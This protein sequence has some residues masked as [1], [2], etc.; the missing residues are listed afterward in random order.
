MNNTICTKVP[1]PWIP[2]ELDLTPTQAIAKVWGRVYTWE[3]S[4]LPVSILTAGKELL[5]APARLRALFDGSESAFTKI[6]YTP[7]SVE[8]EK[9]IFVV[10]A[11]VGNITLNI[12]Y[13]IEYDGFIEMVLSVI[14]FWS[15]SSDP[16]DTVPRL[17]GLYFEFPIR[18]DLSSLYHFWPNGESGII[19][20][21]SIIGSGALPETGL[22]LPFKPYVWSGWE[23]GGLSITTE[24]DENVQLTPGT[25]Y[26]S[27][28]NEADRRVLRWNL[29]N[30]VPHQWFGRV[31]R[32]TE[33]LP[34]VEYKFALQATPV[35]E[36]RKDRMDIRI[37]FAGLDTEGNCLVPDEDGECL[38]DKYQ[39]AGVTWVQF[40]E[41]WSAIQNYGQSINE[42][43][44][45]TYVQE[46]HK[47]GLKIMVYFGY[48]MSTNAPMW[49]EKKN[50]FLIKTSNGSF[51]GGWQRQNP[52]QR[53]YMVC[54]N[55][56]YSQVLCDRIR[57][58]LNEYGVDGI[59]TDSTHVPWECAN[60][61]HGCGYTDIKGVR[62]TTFPIWALR[63]H[64][65]AMYEA[66]HSKEGAINQTH[67]SSCM[68]AP[69]MGFS[70]YLLNGES[71]ADSLRNGFA[72]FLNLPA[73][74]T[75]FM[76]HSIGVPSQLLTFPTEKM[77]MEKYN[78][79]CIIHDT[80][81]G[82]K[83]DSMEY[84]SKFWT[85]LSKFDSC[86]SR[87]YPYWEENSPVR[88][89]TPNTYCSLYENNGKYLAAVSSFNEESDEVVLTFDKNVQVEYAVLGQNVAAAENSTVTV[90]MEAY[91][92]NLIRLS[93]K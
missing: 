11:T 91:K 46:C 32:W 39:Q 86:N 51:T 73:F 42:D 67:N 50:E 66:I 29:L 40:H 64:S 21:P 77:N 8:A 36:L 5:A 17:N 25:P 52:C 7:I 61:A 28:Q 19:P 47:R 93:W 10:G 43:L 92:P 57:Y 48:E 83:P 90:K 9:A 6:T 75:E 44:L 13:T 74:R 76:G 88:S 59:Y 27:I 58:V 49:H 20:D 85:E 14:P 62:H 81:P 45:H 31:D 87:W 26:I 56:D 68:I 12:R 34:P 70:D 89:Q 23:F 24:S 2:V 71:I 54:Y 82:S 37:Q 30:K 78:S 84:V 41:E 16:L 53:D 69:T 80:L 35:K 38:L 4:L 72:E 55:S 60:E 65:K 3:N 33:A 79:L 63:R 18:K 15:C 1:A 22:K